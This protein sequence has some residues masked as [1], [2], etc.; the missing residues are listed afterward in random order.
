MKALATLA[1]ALGALAAAA[2]PAN[3]S[4]RFTETRTLP[5]VKQPL[6]LH[7]TV[8]FRPGQR[9]VWAITAPYRY[10]LAIQAGRIEEQLPDGTTQSGPLAK[11]PWAAA[12]FELFSALFGGDTGALARYFEV[13][14]T[15]GGFVL[16]P[17]SKVLAQ[18]VTRI[19][20]TGRPVPEAV[21]IQE[22][23]GGRIELRFD[24]H[25]PLPAV[26]APATAG[27]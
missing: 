3:Y 23:S 10:R 27:G 7:G 25:S 16:V 21:A 13:T 14:Q 8:S 4:A 15:A 24:A 1:L 12:L 18:S 20:V 22:A 6:V 19:A 26:A 17:R 9:L 5:G 11:A 2:A